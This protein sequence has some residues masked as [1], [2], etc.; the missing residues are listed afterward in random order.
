MGMMEGAEAKVYRTRL[1]GIDAVVKERIEKTYRNETLDGALRTERTKREARIISVASG[2]GSAVPTL[3]LAGR[4]SLVMTRIDGALLCDM[5][6]VKMKTEL[7]RKIFGQ[8][9]S[10]LAELH[11]LGINHGDFTPANL[12]VDRD[13]KVWA[14]DFG[15]ADM[16][17]SV[18]ES[19]LDLLLMKRSVKRS[20]YEAFLK[21]YLKDSGQA[22]AG[23]AKRLREIELRGR[24]QSRTLLTG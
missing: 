18:E 4:N 13:D 12:I 3:L 2:N 15:L 24:Y 5:L 22:G 10:L 17:N 21:R 6:S 11:K 14:I 16:S 20:E 8:A 1:L 7:S 19:A 9:G 23:V